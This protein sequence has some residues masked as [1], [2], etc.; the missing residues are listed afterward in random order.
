MGHLTTV[1]PRMERYIQYAYVR[2][3]M[4]GV[5]GYGKDDSDVNADV[6]DEFRRR[7]TFRG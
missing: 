7:N 6:P 3:K 5:V 1:I 2:S 4:T